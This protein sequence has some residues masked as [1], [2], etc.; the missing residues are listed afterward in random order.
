[1][2]GANYEK[3]VEIVTESISDEMLD[4]YRNIVA[5][6]NK[7]IYEVYDQW[8]QRE[9]K[10]INISII[11]NELSKNYAVFECTKDKVRLT[12]FDSK[13]DLARYLLSYSSF[14]PQI[15]KFMFPITSDSSTTFEIIN[16]YEVK[17]GNEIIRIEEE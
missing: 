14:V 4:P 17:I 11:N 10:F 3:L 16:S 2:M 13:I 8:I 5:V 12:G 15:Y 7:D 1:M 9:S 6:E